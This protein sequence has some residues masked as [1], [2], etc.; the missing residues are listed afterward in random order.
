MKTESIIGAF[1]GLG[2]TTLFTWLLSQGTV[3]ELTYL[4]LLSGTAA[5]A[6]VTHG[7]SRLKEFDLKN[8]KLTLNE[9][10]P[11]LSLTRRKL[12]DDAAYYGP[13]VNVKLLKEALS[14]MK[15]VFPLR[16]C[17]KFHKKVCLEY[18]IAQCPGDR[19]SVV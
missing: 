6:L 15:R 16:S 10:Y 4:A 9:E 11:R 3:S 14:F 19:K 13:Y 18:H 1:I 17:R 8:L 7:F 12:N 5:V 2:G